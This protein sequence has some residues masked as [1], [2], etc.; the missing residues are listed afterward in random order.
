MPEGL[1]DGGPVPAGLLQA[2]RHETLGILGDLRPKGRVERYLPTVDPGEDRVPRGREERRVAAEQ[3]EGDRANTPNVCRS[4]LFGVV[5]SHILLLLVQPIGMLFDDVPEQLSV[6]E[7]ILVLHVLAHAPGTSHLP[8]LHISGE[9][10]GRVASSRLPLRLLRRQLGRA[11]HEAASLE[12]L[13]AVRVLQVRPTAQVLDSVPAVHLQVNAEVDQLQGRM[14]RVAEKAK[15]VRCEAPVIE[16]LIVKRQ[17]RLQHVLHQHSRFLF[18]EVLPLQDALVDRAPG[19]MLQQQVH[20]HVVLE[21]LED[22]CN[23]LRVG[24]QLLQRPDV[25]AKPFLRR[26]TLRLLERS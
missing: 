12:E 3:Q 18:G 11:E 8:I 7:V 16:V 10:N 14:R 24:A 21:H 13:R 2:A 15:R 17:Q 26:Q 25:R 23:G 4:K 9:R 6:Q 22:L 5:A 1:P 20:V 19:A